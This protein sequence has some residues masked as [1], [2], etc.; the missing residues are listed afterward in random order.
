MV[1]GPG[2]E[3]DK[4]QAIAIAAFG[5]FDGDV[6]DPLL[7]AVSAAYCLVACADGDLDDVE[8]REYVR[9]AQA[10]ARFERGP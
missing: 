8:L 9:V 7:R 1:Y 10:D 3:I 2:M 4:S 6:K 5:R